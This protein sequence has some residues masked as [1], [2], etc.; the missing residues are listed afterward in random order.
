MKISLNPSNCFS[1]VKKTSVVDVITESL[2]EI[3]CN[4]V[5]ICLIGL[6][7]LV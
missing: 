7:L 2:V 4:P 6:F 1:Q 3:D 5:D